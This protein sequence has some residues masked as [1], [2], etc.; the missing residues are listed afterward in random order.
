MSDLAY[1]PDGCTCASHASIRAF[2]AEFTPAPPLGIPAARINANVKRL[3]AD[4]AGH[5]DNL[6]GP[7]LGAEFDTTG[8]G[9]LYRDEGMWRWDGIADRHKKGRGR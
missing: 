6:T 3:A 5:E 1:H 8:A 4:G 9:H 7:N 2:L